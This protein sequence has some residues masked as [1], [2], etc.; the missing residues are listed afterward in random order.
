MEVPAQSPF[1]AIFMSIRQHILDA[2]D[3]NDNSVYIDQDLGQLRNNTR[4]PVTWPCILID[5]EEFRYENLAE[6]VQTAKGTVLVQL[7]FAPYSNS[8]QVTPKPYIQQALAY[9]DLETILNWLLE[10][11][12]P[13]DTSGA[14]VRTS[15][16]TQKRND[17]YRVRELR[18]SLAFDDYTTKTPR[19]KSKVTLVLTDEIALPLPDK[20]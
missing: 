1:T 14:L 2:L 9:Y 18:Y 11:W 13:T 16:C 12:E 3:G 17:R 15:V 8:T 5:F 7:G 19:D 6:N 4:P 10:G 20:G